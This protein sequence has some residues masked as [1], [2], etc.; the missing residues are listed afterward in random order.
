[1]ERGLPARRSH[2]SASLSLEDHNTILQQ[3]AG[4]DARAPTGQ[5]NYILGTITIY[6][7]RDS[8]RA[9][10][11]GLDESSPYRAGECRSLDIPPIRSYHLTLAIAMRLQ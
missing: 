10:D 5:S 6:R 8:H 4:K 1:M 11:D 3:P 2:D 9:I 7:A